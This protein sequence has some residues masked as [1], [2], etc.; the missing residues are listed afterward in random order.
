MA[1]A[2]QSALEVFIRYTLT[3]SSR[4]PYAIFICI[5]HRHLIEEDFFNPNLESLS[6][7]MHCCQSG[8]HIQF[9]FVL[10]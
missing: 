5:V 2:V 9:P 3:L 4:I 8:K 1:S 7:S 6:S 10:V